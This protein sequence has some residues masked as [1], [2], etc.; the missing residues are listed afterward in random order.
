MKHAEC[1][2]MTS[3]SIGLGTDGAW[4]LDSAA[5]QETKKATKKVTKKAQTP[6]EIEK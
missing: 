4:A 3:S 5:S 2:L 1:T 6:P